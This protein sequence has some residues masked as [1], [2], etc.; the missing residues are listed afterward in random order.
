MYTSRRSPYRQHGGAATSDVP[1]FLRRQRHPAQDIYRGRCRRRCRRPRSGHTH[2]HAHAHTHTHTHTHI[3]TLGPAWKCGSTGA[4]AVASSRVASCC[5]PRLA[6]LVQRRV[7]I[8]VSIRVVIYYDM[9]SDANSDIDNDA[10]AV[11]VEAARKTT[12][13]PRPSGSRRGE[14]GTVCLQV[15]RSRRAIL[16]GSADSAHSC[17]RVGGGR[18]AAFA[19]VVC[20][21]GRAASRPSERRLGVP[22]ARRRGA[23]VEGT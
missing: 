20:P 5:S 18:P 3:H 21:P 11:G 16:G 9:D 14:G 22:A 2:T 7:D 8:G 4:P 23:G 1:P 19:E 17:A 15:V 10:R 6:P 12:S 13:R